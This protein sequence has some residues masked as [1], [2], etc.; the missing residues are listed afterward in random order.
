MRG[1][2]HN[3]L[4][5]RPATRGVEQVRAAQYKCV[6]V[7]RP[8]Q[9]EHHCAVGKRSTP[10]RNGPL[11][12]S[13]PGRSSHGTPTRTGRNSRKPCAA[14]VNAP[15]VGGRT[16]PGRAGAIGDAYDEPSPR[17][18]SPGLEPGRGCPQRF[19]RPPRLP[20]RQPGADPQSATEVC[21]GGTGS[22]APVRQEQVKLPEMGSVVGDWLLKL[23]LPERSPGAMVSTAS[24]PLVNQEWPPWA[25]KLTMPDPR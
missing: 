6:G 12:W 18:P 19:L 17:V 13:S 7:G 10:R 2:D 8:V 25:M 9:P 14:P 21:R 5:H 24:P 1:R 22:S 11:A 3:P 23:K 15:P 16:S 20:F 4:L